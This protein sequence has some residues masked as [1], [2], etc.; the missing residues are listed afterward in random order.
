M[1][2]TMEIESTHR[3]VVREASQDIICDFVDGQAFGSVLGVG[4]RSVSGWW[5][6]MSVNAANSTATEVCQQA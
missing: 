4:F 1:T 2:L 3:N 5:T 6:V